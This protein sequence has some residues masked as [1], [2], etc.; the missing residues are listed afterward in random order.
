MVQR[1]GLS[2]AGH[3]LI[4]LLATFLKQARPIEHESDGEMRGTR[5]ERQAW[6][7]RLELVTR[8][9]GTEDNSTGEEGQQWLVCAGCEFPLC[10]EAEISEEKFET[11]QN[12]TYTYELCGGLFDRD[13]W[14][15]SA[16][17]AYDHRFDVIRTLPTAENRS[18]FCRERPT[19][20]FSWF[21]GFSWSICHCRQCLEHVGWAFS[22]EEP[23]TEIEG[24]TAHPDSATER[25]FATGTNRTSELP[26]TSLRPIKRDVAFCALILTKLRAK[27]LS[28]TEENDIFQ[29]HAEKIE[30]GRLEV[31]R[32]IKE[33]ESAASLAATA[34]ADAAAEAERVARFASE[35]PQGRKRRSRRPC[36][37]RQPRRW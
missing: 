14:C 20:E 4:T 25:E 13:V 3:V 12:V 7:G 6:R 19:S 18:V 16:T 5:E 23:A 35:A 22:P 11:W 26:L 32:C 2:Q 29:A 28:Q 30:R 8:R 36:R 34:A 31:Q 24:A 10:S 37:Q 15:Y 33:L 27:H 21:P 17:N 1:I 9:N